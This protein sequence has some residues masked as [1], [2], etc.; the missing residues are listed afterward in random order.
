MNEDR[1][2][3]LEKMAQRALDYMEIQN[4]MAAHTFLYRAQ[5]QEEEM[6]LFWTHQK[7]DIMYAHGDMAFVGWDTV[8]EYYVVNNARRRKAT[9]EMMHELHPDI[10]NIAQNEGIGDLPAHLM[11]TPYIEIAGDG[12]TA[13]GVWYSPTFLS[14]LTTEGT[15]RTFVGLARQGADFVKEDGKWKIWHLRDFSDVTFPVTVPGSEKKPDSMD[16][17]AAPPSLE[18]PGYSRLVNNMSL[19]YHERYGPTAIPELLPNLPMPYESW[20]DERSLMNQ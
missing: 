15:L 1:L 6:E 7:E 19:S 3:N 12:M 18:R 5:R 17:K 11:T 8:Y 2:L 9:L 10:E 14:G 20:S 16:A 13:Q 4:A